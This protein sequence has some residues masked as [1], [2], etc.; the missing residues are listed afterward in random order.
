ML[1]SPIFLVPTN[2]SDHSPALA[3]HNP[4]SVPGQ[5]DQGARKL[6]LIKKIETLD[7]FKILGEVHYLYSSKYVCVY[8]CVCVCAILCNMLL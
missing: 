1:K 7:T 5:D 6:W 4:T 2:L 3:G 8:L